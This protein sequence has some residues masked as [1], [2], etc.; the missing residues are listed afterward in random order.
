MH[1]RWR[2]DALNLL[3]PA[4]FLGAAYLRLSGLFTA[5]LANVDEIAALNQRDIPFLQGALAHSNFLGTTVV[6]KTL[7]QAVDFPALRLV[8]VGFSLVALWAGW[9]ALRGLASPGVALGWLALMGGSWTVIYFGRLF[10]CGAFDPAVACLMLAAVIGW[11]RDRTR[12]GWLVAAGFLLGLHANNHVLPVVYALLGYGFWLLS[13]VRAKELS[14]GAVA[15]VVGAATLGM[16]PFF[17]TSLGNPA[18][19]GA[20]ENSYGVLGARPELTWAINLRAPDFALRT[21]AAYFTRYPLGEKIVLELSLTLGLLALVGLALWRSPSSGLKTYLAWFCGGSL[22]VIAL[23][24]FP[25]YN[26]GHFHFFWPHFL[27]L[28]ALMLAQSRGALRVALGAGTLGL[29]AYNASWWPQIRAN[30]MGVL[31]ELVARELPRTEHVVLAGG[32]RPKLAPT[33]VWPFLEKVGLSEV[34]FDR[35]DAMQAVVQGPAR[36]TLLFVTTDVPW[37]PERIETRFV[38]EPVYASEQLM[39]AHQTHGLRAYR[40]TPRLVDTP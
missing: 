14:L 6:L 26:E 28:L 27:A 40:L 39:E 33:P 37:P 36:P 24:P 16:V 13:R 11:L 29:A 15:A 25:A 5:Q 12:P 35:P 1:S 38:V 31:A 3:L 10:E 20:L 18:V 8:T 22:A 32:A 21:L 9:R 30:Q 34:V 4:L 2:D 23:S 7:G 17:I 19:A